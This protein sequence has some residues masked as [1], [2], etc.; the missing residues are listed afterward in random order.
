M[1]TI[2]L[3]A[4][5]TQNYCGVS[6]LGVSHCNI[7]IDENRDI[8][9]IRN[10]LV[11]VAYDYLL[12]FGSETTF[13]WKPRQFNGAAILFLFNRYLTLAVQILDCVPLPSSFQVRCLAGRWWRIRS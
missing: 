11:L 2:E 7:L 5:T 13:F 3:S 4:E 8:R 9:I 12:T 10:H 1:L 6:V